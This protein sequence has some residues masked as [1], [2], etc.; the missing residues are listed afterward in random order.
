M[1]RGLPPII[2]TEKDKQD[3]EAFADFM[4]ANAGTVVDDYLSQTP[5]E[6]RPGRR[7]AVL[8]EFMRLAAKIRKVGPERRAELLMEH[9]HFWERNK[10]GE[11]PLMR[12][13]GGQT[14]EPPPGFDLVID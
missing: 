12:P 11:V 4:V 5:S 10:P 7:R 13:S 2:S 3:R 1:R 6:D 14:S 9:K 8:R